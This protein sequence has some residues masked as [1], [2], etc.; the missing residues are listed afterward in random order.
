MDSVWFA[1][2]RTQ[3]STY[4]YFHTPLENVSLFLSCSLPATIPFSPMFPPPPAAAAPDWF[5]QGR[6]WKGDLKAG[7]E[8]KVLCLLLSMVL[9]GCGKARDRQTA[10][11]EMMNHTNPTH[12]RPLTT[13]NCKLNTHTHTGGRQG[14]LAAWKFPWNIGKIT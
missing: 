3:Y 1:G 12:T 2:E 5:I 10:S 4:F 6:W 11:R 9:C 8:E 7:E 14:S 13:L